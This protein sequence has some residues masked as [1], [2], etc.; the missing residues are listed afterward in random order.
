MTRAAGH[1]IA[2]SPEGPQSA[3]HPRPAMFAGEGFVIAST[4]ISNSALSLRVRTAMGLSSLRGLPS[5]FVSHVLNNAF[6]SPGT[7]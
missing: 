3:S 1:L 7:F 2:L 5:N 4:V 6:A